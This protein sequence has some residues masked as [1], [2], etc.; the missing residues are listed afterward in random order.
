MDLA[1]TALTVRSSGRAALPGAAVVAAVV[2]YVAA[3]RLWRGL[4]AVTVVILTVGAVLF[5]RAHHDAL[6]W[7]ALLLAATATAPLLVL[8]RSPLL[9]VGLVAAAN[10]V[11][12]VVSRLPWPPT[13]VLAWLLALGMCPLL[14]SQRQA[15]IVLVGT[16]VAVLT[17][18]CLPVAVN[19][20]PWDA[21]ITEALA[22][23]LVWGAGQSLH[24]RRD[25]ELRRIKDEAQL[26]A[27]QE[28]DAL[29]Q[30]RVGIAR[31]LHDVVA[32][33]VSLIAV[34]AATARYQV[35]DLPPDAR[36]VFEEIAAQARTAL[37]ELRTVLGVLRTPD[38]TGPQAPQP[39][40]A[41][42]PELVER[43]RIRGM[44]ITVHTQG[45]SRSLPDGVE[46]CC[47]RVIQEA[48][49]NAA[50]HA[51]G[52]AVGV[53]IDY[54][55][56]MAVQ[57]QIRNALGEPGQRDRTPPGFGLIGMQERVTALGGELSAGP[58]QTGFQVRVRIPTV[59]IRCAS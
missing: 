59:T 6:P 15:L 38:R 23:L 16:E 18:A 39:S 14:V 5:S 34:R 42:L 52:A 24:S 53:D 7:V 27:L 58:D 44:R 25:W 11:F 8:R 22:V 45:A 37:D 1:S 13:A 48:L 50:R 19:A 30:S 46:L 9:G 21:P 33:H 4:A 51:P 2:S 35:A 17:A 12:V 56:D 57:V 54:G 29:A 26:R 28:R 40:L 36:A 47:Y 31:E 49:T 43:M 10:A 55:S 41:D 3:S 32:H 20:R